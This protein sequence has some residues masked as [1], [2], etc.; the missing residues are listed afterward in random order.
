MLTFTSGVPRPVT[1]SP[2]RCREKMES[3]GRSE[4]TG[5][6]GSEFAKQTLREGHGFLTHKLGS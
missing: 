6:G 3:R 4:E 2:R 1:W 5:L